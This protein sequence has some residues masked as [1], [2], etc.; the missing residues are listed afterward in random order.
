MKN[1]GNRLKNPIAFSGNCMA[2]VY[3]FVMSYAGID[4]SSNLIE[5]Y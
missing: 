1:Q 4:S 2:S 5:K 3:P